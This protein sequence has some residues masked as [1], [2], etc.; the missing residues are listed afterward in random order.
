M[1]TMCLSRSL[2][3]L[4]VLPKT[5]FIEINSSAPVLNPLDLSDLGPATR[6]AA[7]SR[8]G[9]GKRWEGLVSSLKE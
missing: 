3:T 8:A 5:S 4:K 2:N 7:I 6:G 9:K 1:N